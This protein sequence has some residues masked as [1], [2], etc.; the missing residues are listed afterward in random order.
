MFF[1]FFIFNAQF[2]SSDSERCPDAQRP[3]GLLLLF[4]FITPNKNLLNQR[5]VCA[6][7]RVV[8]AYKTQLRHQLRSAALL[9]ICQNLL[10][11]YLSHVYDSVHIT[12]CDWR[13][14]AVIQCI[15]KGRWQCA[16][17][18]VKP[19]EIYRMGLFCIQSIS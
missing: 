8:H 6:R 16:C 12:L 4:S 3:T 1:V 17:A 13:L 7:S 5:L 14:K 19:A 9:L 15:A 10:F 2:L 11:G 18:C